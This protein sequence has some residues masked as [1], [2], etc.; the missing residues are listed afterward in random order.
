M[1]VWVV[2]QLLSGYDIM[3][4]MRNVYNEVKDEAIREK[5][6]ELIASEKDVKYQKKCAGV[7][8]K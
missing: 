8:R 4:S 2:R 3:V 5:V 1:S 6:L 7:W